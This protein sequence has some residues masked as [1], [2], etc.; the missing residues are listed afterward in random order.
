MSLLW[1]IIN[2][3]NCT[4][5]LQPI[6]IENS[7]INIF[8]TL[9]ARIFTT[10]HSWVVDRARRL[11]WFARFL[12]VSE[13]LDRA[14]EI[15]T[16]RRNESAGWWWWATVRFTDS[17]KWTHRPIVSCVLPSNV[18]P[19]RVTIGRMSRRIGRV[20]FPILRPAFPRYLAPPALLPSPLRYLLSSIVYENNVVF[21]TNL[22]CAR[23]SA[24]ISAC[25]RTGQLSEKRAA[26]CARHSLTILWRWEMIG[27]FLAISRI[28]FLEELREISWASWGNCFVAQSKP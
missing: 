19:R 7:L 14:K 25:E 26:K 9:Y 2:Q 15:R 28:Y 12:C 6:N 18:S 27:Q 13:K 11:R 8:T 21:P 16:R 23:A 10:Y 1:S 4:R 5:W 17:D 3:L 20:L 22:S 24:C